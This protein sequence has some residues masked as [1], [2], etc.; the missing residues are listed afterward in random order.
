MAANA[1]LGEALG[2]Q[3]Q[4]VGK[5]PGAPPTRA[6]ARLASRL[7]VGSAEERELEAGGRNEPVTRRAST[8]EWEYLVVEWLSD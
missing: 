3:R 4:F 2:T 6:L 5:R 8:V 7:S 1:D